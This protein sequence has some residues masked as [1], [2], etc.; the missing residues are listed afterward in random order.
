VY[1]QSAVWKHLVATADEPVPWLAMS[2][3]RPV[4]AALR[5]R[6]PRG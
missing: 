1:R 2:A 3:G 6:R 5:S 4:A